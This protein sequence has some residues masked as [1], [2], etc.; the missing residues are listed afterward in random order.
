MDFFDVDAMKAENANAGVELEK[1]VKHIKEILDKP[2]GTNQQKTQDFD[3]LNLQK[4]IPDKKA[5]AKPNA[6]NFMK[7]KTTETKQADLLEGIDILGLDVGGSTSSFHSS[8]PQPVQAAP[9]APAKPN[10]LNFFNKKNEQ[11]KPPQPSG[12]ELSL[13]DMDLLGGPVP[14]TSTHQNSSSHNHQN[15]HFLPHQPHAGAQASASIDLFDLSVPATTS[16]PTASTGITM[17][18]SGTAAQQKQPANTGKGGDLLSDLTDL[19]GF[20]SSSKGQAQKPGQQPAKSS[21]PFDFGL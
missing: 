17:H 14:P 16:T 1:T 11:P 10:A 5:P 19:S 15:H 2:Y 9:A 7:G 12:A 8:N 3:P 13:L 21:D 4:D 18:G 6:L 20:T